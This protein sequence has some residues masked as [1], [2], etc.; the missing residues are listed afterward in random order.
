MASSLDLRGPYL[1]KVTGFDSLNDD[2]IHLILLFAGKKSFIPCGVLN[3]RCNQIFLTHNIPKETFLYGYA[4]LPLIKEK[5]KSDGLC[6]S[7]RLGKAIVYYNRND[8]L[9]RW[10][11]VEG[12]SNMSWA[13]ALTCQYAAKLGRIDL[14]KEV[15]KAVSKEISVCIKIKFNSSVSSSAAGNGQLDT[16]KWLKVNEWFDP[17]VCL[18]PAAK[19]GHLHVIEWLQNQEYS[20]CFDAHTFSA[21]AF[22]GSLEVMKFLRDN[23]CPFDKT[24][25]ACAARNGNLDN[26]QWLLNHN[27]PWGEDCYSYAAESRQLHCLEWLKQNGCPRGD[28]IVHVILVGLVCGVESDV[29]N[30]LLENGFTLRSL[31]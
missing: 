1:T 21:A 11:L 3:K 27:C 17:K 9:H 7:R 28:G 4:P 13:T 30:W 22:G 12:G 14:L 5:V 23:N 19:G 15:K 6:S 20:P 18:G 8:I 26:C 29:K 16:L 2:A 25:F 10:I 31:Y 24:T